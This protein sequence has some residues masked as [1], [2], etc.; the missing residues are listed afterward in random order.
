LNNV[1]RTFIY[2]LYTECLLGIRRSQEWLFPLGFFIIV[3]CSFP[4]AFTPDERLLQTYF[5]GFVWLAALFATMLSAS[6]FFVADLEDGHIEQ[7]VLTDLP[8]SVLLIAKLIANWII[9]L[10]PLLLL[11][12]FL[13]CMFHVTIVSLIALWLGLLAGSPA[14]IFISSFGTSLTMGLKQQGVILGLLMLPL[15]I[16]VLIFGVSTVL[17]AQAGINYFGS[18]ALLSMISLLSAITLPPASAY[19]L[20]ANL[21]D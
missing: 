11:T 19:V 21:D 20:K 17:E 7:Y 8:L 1:W 6:T 13:G 15:M 12:P 9:Y 18:L 5:P 2:I 3:V 4:L 14:L 10:L 16:P